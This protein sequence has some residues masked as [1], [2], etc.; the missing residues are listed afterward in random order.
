MQNNLVFTREPDVEYPG[1]QVVDPDDHAEVGE[2][3]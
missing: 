3:A 1:L 2:H